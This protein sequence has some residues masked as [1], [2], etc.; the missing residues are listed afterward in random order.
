VVQK[1][2][3][4]LHNATEIVFKYLERDKVIVW[5]YATEFVMSY[6]WKSLLEI[7]TQEKIS[8]RTQ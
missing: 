1:K 4:S 8:K 7:W 3:L 2:D 6:T 5:S